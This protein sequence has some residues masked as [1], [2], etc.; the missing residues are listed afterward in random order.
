MIDVAWAANGQSGGTGGLLQS[1]LPLILIFVVFY[2][3][4][5]MPQRRK[6]RQHRELLASLDKGAKI[7]TSGGIYGTITRAHQNY[8]EVEITNGTVVRVLR[9]AISTV[10]TP[11]SE[12]QDTQSK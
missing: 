8:V 6:Q 9:S 10:R 1:L 2:F 3:L 7:V 5:I 4:L 12:V 11:E